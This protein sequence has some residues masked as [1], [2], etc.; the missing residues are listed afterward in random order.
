MRA[1][2]TFAACLVVVIVASCAD[3][4]DQAD[5]GMLLRQSGNPAPEN[6]EVTP[7]DE[8]YNGVI[9]KQSGN[10]APDNMDVTPSDEEDSP[11]TV[12]VVP[13]SGDACYG[14]CR[15]AMD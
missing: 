15:R 3:G 9:T 7:P 2:S 1:L 5:H 14:E 8:G 10:P 12:I 6:V 4:P 11:M 13:S